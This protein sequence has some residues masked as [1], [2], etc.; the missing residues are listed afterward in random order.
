[1]IKDR[2]EIV[3][4][5]REYEGTPYINQGRLKN[6][7]VDCLGLI[8]NVS[9]ECGFEIGEDRK[10]YNS[11]PDGIEMSA[12]L[13]KRFDQISFDEIQDGDIILF[14]FLKNPQH[15]AFY[16]NH[17]GIDYMT[18]SYGETNT[19]KVVSHRLDSVWKKRI[20]AVFRFKELKLEE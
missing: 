11:T 20:S 12:E 14:R 17:E 7:G 16:F 5:F 3:K 10:D 8:M 6:H 15:L 2:K 9:K 18:H 4:I 13:N 1:M 19:M